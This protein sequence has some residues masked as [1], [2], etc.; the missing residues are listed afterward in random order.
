MTN[1]FNGAIFKLSLLFKKTKLAA[2]KIN[3]LSFFPGGGENIYIV[4]LFWRLILESKYNLCSLET[5][6][7]PGVKSLCSK[8]HGCLVTNELCDYVWKSIT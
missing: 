7:I 1:F 6:W 4:W 3:S 2:K 8:I 5:V